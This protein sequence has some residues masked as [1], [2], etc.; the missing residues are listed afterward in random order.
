[1]EDKVSIRI[2]NLYCMLCYAF[3]LPQQK[4]DEEIRTQDFENIYDLFTAILAIGISRQLRRGLNRQYISR[5]ESLPL[6][7]GRLDIAGTIKDQLSRK[8]LLSCTYDELS[9]N[10]LLNRILKST[11]LYLLRLPAAQRGADSVQKTMHAFRDRLKSQ[12]T[13]FSQV[14]PID[15][16]SIDWDRISYHRHNQSYRLLI[17]ICRLVVEG[18]LLTTET[19]ETKLAAF[20]DENEMHWVYEKFLLEYYRTHFPI[21]SPESRALHWAIDEKTD[22]TSALL[23]QL[24]G[25][26]TDIHLQYGRTVLIL[27]AKYY[28]QNTI[29]RYGKQF[30]H[31]GNLYQIF[32]YVKN[33]RY[34]MEKQGNSD[35]VVS[36]LLLY[37][38]TMDALQ[39]E[40]TYLIHGNTIGALSLDLDPE[41]KSIS[42][43]LNDIVWKYFHIKPTK[44]VSYAI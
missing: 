15:L 7:R 24:P 27:D 16:T 37:A 22:E 17:G 3:Q 28:G 23:P 31:S 13:F 33:R 38:G 5:T 6:L 35:A 25:M 9:E 44:E 10:S 1:M 40:N 12:M 36:G 32:T 43:K 14:D 2:R 20:L 4:D 30:L 39:P 34:E 8:Q 19:G 41:F 18:R 11:A 21:L 26:Q 29:R 42:D